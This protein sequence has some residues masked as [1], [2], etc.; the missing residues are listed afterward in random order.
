MAI[1]RRGAADAKGCMRRR[2]SWSQIRGVWFGLWSG[3]M[4]G[5]ASADRITE[6]VG[7]RTM[8]PVAFTMALFV[9]VVPDAVVQVY[10]GLRR[11][12]AA[13]KRQPQ[14]GAGLR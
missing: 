2:F 6:W 11:F 12:R 13:A 10:R 1:W 9:A 8:L 4:L 3:L 5:A 14:M 7:G